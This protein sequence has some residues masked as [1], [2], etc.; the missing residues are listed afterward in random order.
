MT[1]IERTVG[2]FFERLM[3]YATVY[4]N[5]DFHDDANTAI[6]T[7]VQDSEMREVMDTEWSEV[8]GD[9]E[10]DRVSISVERVRWTR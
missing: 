6:N 4:Y 7:Y 5:V 1:S 8:V 3:Y 10:T 9:C 2:R